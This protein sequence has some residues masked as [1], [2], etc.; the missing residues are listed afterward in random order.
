MEP[1]IDQV[2]LARAAGGEFAAQLEKQAQTDRQR[3]WLKR[4]RDQT[5]RAQTWRPRKK[6]RGSARRWIL[7]VDN[8]VSST[9]T[10]HLCGG[11]GGAGFGAKLVSHGFPRFVWSA[12]KHTPA[13]S[14]GLS[15]VKNTFC[16]RDLLGKMS[17]IVF[18]FFFRNRFFPKLATQM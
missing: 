4:E 18:P 7:L 11:R 12:C 5:E 15:E 14:R 17:E 3:G 8:A 1:L 10:L 2:D 6:H 16:S 13:G 9:R